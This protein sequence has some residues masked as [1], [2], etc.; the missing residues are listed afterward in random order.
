[1]QKPSY[2]L[3]T[4]HMICVDDY[5][6]TK[7]M[8]KSFEQSEELC[9]EMDLDDPTIIMQLA[10]AMINKEGKELK[11]YFTTE[12]YQIVADYYE[13]K[14]GIDIAMFAPM[15]PIALQTLMATNSFDCD[16]SV[17]YEERLSLLAGERNIEITGLETAEEQ[18][19]LLDAIPT[20]SVIQQIIAY[21]KDEGDDSTYI[22]MIEAYTNQ[23]IVSLHEIILNSK[24]IG[25]NLNLFL[26][27]RN[28]KWIDHMADRMDQKSVFFAVGAGHL[29]GEAGL[30]SLLRNNGYTVIPVR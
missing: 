28:I 17:S 16:S 22:S 13:T 1:M 6:W 18:I 23:D 11:D 29:W 25:A 24:E 26:D 5:I 20:D 4:I 27:D 15:K 21:T 2:L 7:A 3:G 9:L 19:K 12:E 8:Q 14:L 10:T 30:I